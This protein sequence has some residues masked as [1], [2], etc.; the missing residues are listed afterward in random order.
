MF[1]IIKKS[2]KTRVVTGQYPK[3][4]AVSGQMSP[5]AIHKAKPFQRSLTIREVD[6]GSCNAC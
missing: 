1:R 2:L 6:T 3:T 5:E 4:E